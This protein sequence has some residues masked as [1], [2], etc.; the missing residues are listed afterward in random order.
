MMLGRLAAAT[1]ILAAT[2]STLCAAADHRLLVLDGSWVKWG[3]LQWGAG[4][5]VTYA[6]ASGPQTSPG[7][8]NC[9]ALQPFAELVKRTGLPQAQ[10]ESAAQSAFTAWSEV[11]GLTFIATKDPARAD[12]VIGAQG[13]P[14]GRAFTNVELEAGPVAQAPAV[15]RGFTVAAEP[16]SHGGKPQGLRQIRKALICFNALEKWKIGFDGDLDV[17]DLRYTLTHE[18]GHAIGLDHPGAAGALMGFR[19]D[20]KQNSL[21]RGDIAAVQ[22]LYGPR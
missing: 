7:A 22:R 1:F 2:M 10:V 12:I 5:T 6:F 17:Y 15:E 18:I 4:A 9:A 16:P 13:N 19:Y 14:A 8:R 21:T 20:E 3:K 11:T